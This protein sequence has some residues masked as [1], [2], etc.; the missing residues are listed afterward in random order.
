MSE[1]VQEKGKNVEMNDDRERKIA[2]CENV[3]SIYSPSGKEEKLASYIHSELI[4]QGIAPRIDPAGN[5]IAETGFGKKTL[6]LCGHMDT[7]PG[8]LALKREG[9][10]L[11]GRGACDAKG[12]LLSI[13]FAFE[14]IAGEF[15]S[16]ADLANRGKVIFAGVVQE[17]KESKGLQELINQ[18]LRSDAAIF[19][20]PAGLQKVTIGYRGH[21]PVFL[22]ISTRE[23]HGSAPWLGTNAIEVAVDLYKQIKR[24]LV[25]NEK[26][27]N[28]FSVAMTELH[29]GKAQ[30]VIPGSAQA[31][32][33]IR[34]PLGYTFDKV[35]SKIK[36]LVAKQESKLDCSVR[37]TFGKHT[38]PY[39]AKLDS[40]VIRALNR[41]MLKLGFGK[42]SFVSKSGTGDMNTYALHFGTESVTYGPGD[43]ALSHTEK[44]AIDLEEIFDCSRVLKQTAL[45]F[46]S[47]GG[48]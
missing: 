35:S 28:S 32:L 1:L 44:E 41:S 48:S 46:F 18:D 29:S 3:L 34:V 43:T 8:E 2:I 33:D 4:S 26:G 20:E 21:I 39:R 40:N 6:L 17:E 45:E 14:E 30:N 10:T 47:L 42:P 25:E 36:K 38:E 31:T 12:P 16:N 11:Y 27:T 37:M 24:A 19:G 15:R 9:T 23:A 5:V 7:V 13:L 22:D